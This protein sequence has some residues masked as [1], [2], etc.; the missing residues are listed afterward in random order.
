MMTDCCHITSSSAGHNGT[1]TTSHQHCKQ[2]TDTAANCKN[3]M[4]IEITGKHQSGAN[5]TSTM[6]ANKNNNGDDQNDHS[7][8][9]SST[10]SS[11]S[12]TGGG[13]GSGSEAEKKSKA[14]K[15]L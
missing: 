9:S 4:I 13:G 12:S 6:S 10:S 8:S 5:R 14:L 1:N 15:S 2:S 11:K 3:E 7:I